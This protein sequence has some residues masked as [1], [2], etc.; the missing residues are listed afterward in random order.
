MR[1]ISGMSLAMLK[2]VRQNQS[3]TTKNTI[4]DNATAALERM[5]KLNNEAA[6]R[7]H[8]RKQKK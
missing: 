3:Q 2:K 5:R 6:I 1:R 7:E 8:V 4:R